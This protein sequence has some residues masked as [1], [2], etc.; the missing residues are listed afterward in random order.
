MAQYLTLSPD[1]TRKIALGE[2]TV[3]IPAA[4]RGVV[5]ATTTL[6]GRMSLSRH[7]LCYDGS[8]AY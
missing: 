6:R 5:D 2:E 7:S 4:R 1:H 8:C 3:D